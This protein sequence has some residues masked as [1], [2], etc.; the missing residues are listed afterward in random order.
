ML[1]R[2]QVRRNRK[3]SIEL[4]N[5][6]VIYDL[7]ERPSGNGREGEKSEWDTEMEE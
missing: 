1:L 7:D 6:E 4:S 2:G 3:V 5:V